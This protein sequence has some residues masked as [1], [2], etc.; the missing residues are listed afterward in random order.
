M[1]VMWVLTLTVL[2]VNATDIIA[3]L[4]ENVSK[5]ILP[6]SNC[7][8]LLYFSSSFWRSFFLCV[9]LGEHPAAMQ[10]GCASNNINISILLYIITFSLLLQQLNG[11]THGI[12]VAD[13]PF[14]G[15]RT[16][17]R[18][19]YV[20]AN[21]KHV[22]KVYNGNNGSCIDHSTPYFACGHNQFLLT[23]HTALTSRWN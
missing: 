4:R 14:T 15:S 7:S 10:R 17:C 13:Q 5:H 3:V 16:A 21:D 23:I 11:I 8:L 18:D 2:C 12:I 22:D 9:I 20:R 6:N 19:H 1:C